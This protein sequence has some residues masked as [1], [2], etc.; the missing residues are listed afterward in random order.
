M[1]QPL[2]Q[3]HNFSSFWLRREVS[4]QTRPQISRQFSPLKHGLSSLLN[5]LLPAAA[6]YCTLLG[7]VG[8]NSA[9]A[10]TTEFSAK[11]QACKQNHVWNAS[12]FAHKYSLI[13]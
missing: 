7:Y 12:N 6:A 5:P 2:R 3:K 4:I 1:Q 13:Y 8:F 10:P 11:F 9:Q